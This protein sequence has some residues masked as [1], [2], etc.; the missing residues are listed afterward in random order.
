MKVDF[1][2][3]ET[4]RKHE[5][6]AVARTAR[7]GPDR[8]EEWIAAGTSAD[9]ARAEILAEIA[10]GTIEIGEGETE[11]YVRQ[12]TEA[13]VA[14]AGMTEAVDVARR[15]SNVPGL[16]KALKGWTREST[17]G[18]MRGLSFGEMAADS[19]ERRGQRADRRNYHDTIGRCLGIGGALARSQGIEPA[20]TVQ[21][22]DY[23]GQSLSDFQHALLNSI[24]V[25][26][27]AAY[28]RASE[29]Y[30]AF[31]KVMLLPDFKTATVL[32]MG[33]M[34]GTLST[35]DE[36]GTIPVN[37]IADATNA[38]AVALETEGTQLRV[39]RHVLLADRADLIRDVASTAGRAA[40]IHLEKKVFAVLTANGGLGK[41]VTW[42]GVTA[43]LIDA[44]YNNLGTPATLGID[45]LAADVAKLRSQV[46]PGSGEP[47]NLQADTLLVPVVLDPLA[48][49]VNASRITP[50][51]PGADP[52]VPA[53][54]GGIVRQVVSSP[55][56][57][58]TMRYVF[59]APDVCAAVAL[60]FLDRGEMSQLP[61]IETADQWHAWDFDGLKVRLLLDSI[62]VPLEPLG[63]VGNVGA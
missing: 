43:N 32:R 10:S 27:L 59:A 1:E 50:G 12:M 41:Q 13:I 36:G 29:T 31:T 54:S 56:L 2:Q 17:G 58:G 35:I 38:G 23:P 7:L 42:N 60:A 49:Q 52:A 47:L 25:V 44:Q 21:R 63:V 57:T 33:S 9:E 16:A 48:N 61:I 3:Q 53:F 34:I 40:A 5:L 14:K 46:D 26:A 28:A 51:A 18:E 20:R 45:G 30:R 19:L 4:E 62:A 24:R 39:S 15:S 11:K 6:R 37:V 22:R 55:R 8:A